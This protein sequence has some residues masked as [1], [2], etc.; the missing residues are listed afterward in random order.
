MPSIIRT[1]GSLR[2]SYTYCQYVYALSY[3]LKKVTKLS[4]IIEAYNYSSSVEPDLIVFSIR[5]LFQIIA[6]DFS[7]RMVEEYTYRSRY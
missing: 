5:T 4:F 3:H 2:V 1:Q 6:H 7:F